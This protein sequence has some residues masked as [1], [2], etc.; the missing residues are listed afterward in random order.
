MFGDQTVGM[1]ESYSRLPHLFSRKTSYTPVQSENQMQMLVALAEQ[2]QVLYLRIADRLHSLRVLRSLPIQDSERLKIAQEALNVYAPLAH[3]MGLMKVKG[4][5]EDEAFRVINPDLFLES[6]RTQW[7]A[8]K[9]L[10]DGYNKIQDVLS[11]DPFLTSQ[12]VTY[13]MPYRV[14]DKYQLALKMARKNLK[15]LSEVRDA[16]GMRIIIDAPRFEG[17]SEQE[18]NSRS[19]KLCYYIV[20][21]VRGI[22]GWEPAA[23]KGFKDYIQQPKGN[24]YQSLHQYIRHLALDSNLEVQVR[25]RQMHMQAE[26][27][28]AAHWNYKDNMYRPDIASSKYYNIAWRSPEQQ[29]AKSAA[30]LIGLAKKQLNAQRVFVFLEDEA[31]VL[32]LS[33]GATSLD[34]AFAIHTNVGLT[35]RSISVSDEPCGMKRVMRNGDVLSVECGS[36][37]SAAPSWLAAARL[38]YTKGVLRKHLRQKHQNRIFEYRSQL[39]GYD[40]DTR[41][42]RDM[43]SDDDDVAEKNKLDDIVA[44][45]LAVVPPVVS[46]IDTITENGIPVPPYRASIPFWAMSAVEKVQ[47]P[48][49]PRIQIKSQ[50]SRAQKPYSLEGSSISEGLQRLAK[51]HV[52]ASVLKTRAAW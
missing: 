35:A 52:A 4:E 51:R 9:A 46:V 43:T 12:N 18:H 25:T 24:G 29:K 14:K 41:E 36:A 33:K 3:K 11:Q 8:D 47:G 49:C 34:A 42:S 10:H 37:V 15:S 30:E 28:E 20:D 19:E 5:L 2:Y 38:P 27:G 48:I 39:Y 45:V 1:V 40:R 50:I 21:K 44:E 31:T 17:E 32:N 7:I 16:V 13:R 22:E 26:L 23:E 6:K